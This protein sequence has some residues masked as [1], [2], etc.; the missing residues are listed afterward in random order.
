[1]RTTD[2][3]KFKE[4]EG[5]FH[6]M[7]N[8]TDKQARD[9]LTNAEQ[10]YERVKS[11]YQNTKP[12]DQNA[13]KLVTELA[14]DAIKEFGNTNQEKKVE[15]KQWKAQAE[16]VLPPATIEDLRKR[17]E[18]QLLKK[19]YPKNKFLRNVLLGAVALIVVFLGLLTL[20]KTLTSNETRTAPSPAVK[21]EELPKE[22]VER[23]LAGIEVKLLDR[24]LEVTVRN[25]TEWEVREIF[26]TFTAFNRQNQS[27]GYMSDIRL[28]L[29]PES[30][31]EAYRVSKFIGELGVDWES[32]KPLFQLQ[33]VRAKGIKPAD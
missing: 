30:T 17:A 20:R 33:I 12:L 21:L 31:G 10:L 22:L 29:E 8:G 11:L 13:A 4:V 25:E 23:R 7:E 1:M 6:N 3:E 19:S 28:G 5:R 26:V 9:G 32:A 14:D 18:G 24:S 2:I 15:L 16:L 27:I